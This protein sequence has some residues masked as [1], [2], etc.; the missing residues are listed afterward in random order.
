MKKKFNVQNIHNMIMI[1]NFKGGDVYFRYYGL[2]D[3]RNGK[4]I[5]KIFVSKAFLCN[6][7]SYIAKTY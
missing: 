7:M 1:N 3:G 2:A 5:G 6:F 4:N